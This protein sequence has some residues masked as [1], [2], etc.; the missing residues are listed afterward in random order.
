MSTSDEMPSDS[1]V[2]ANTDATV[3]FDLLDKGGDD[4]GYK[5]HSDEEKVLGSSPQ[6]IMYK[7]WNG[8][9][10]PFPA[11]W[12]LD[13]T[14]N[15]ILRHNNNSQYT[16]ILICG[17]SGSGKSTLFGTMIH[18]LLEKDQTY[19]I[20]K[21]TGEDLGNLDN[22]INSL[23]VGSNHILVFDDASYATD[24]ID[25]KVL[26]KLAYTLTVI[27]HKV[28]A[29][30]ITFMVVHYSK[31]MFKF[32]R[33]VPFVIYTSVNAE[34]L[35]N[36]MDLYKQH[37]FTVRKFAS[38]YR[39][40]TLR[41]WFSTDISQYD[42]TKISYAIDK[43]FRISMI[44]EASDLHLMLYYKDSC[45]HCDPKTFIPPKDTK[46]IAC[47]LS[48]R[49]GKR[50][51]LPLKLWAS[52]KSKDVEPPVLY[53]S[54]FHYLN[55]LGREV[56]IDYKSL[57]DEVEVLLKKH[58]YGNKKK[59][60]QQYTATRVEIKNIVDRIK[61]EFD[62]MKPPIDQNL[63]PVETEKTDETKVT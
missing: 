16:G 39:Q 60:W 12:S 29:K 3:N 41:G 49:Y 15:N 13:I 54:I 48:A 5:I 62:Q 40:M 11:R 26:K 57:V 52:F 20:K 53:Q 1:F 38:M 36:Y 21:F 63:P 32:F 6:D 22:I 4:S 61:S 35:G 14:I 18:K 44:E 59:R 19:I 47:D 23:K 25:N 43:P 10:V 8:K 7:L 24:D 58:N 28:K 37:G 30:V 55:K 31:A 17:Q 9:K 2:E 56:A 33:A 46:A 51:L 27:R 50:L 45:E 34:E 42:G